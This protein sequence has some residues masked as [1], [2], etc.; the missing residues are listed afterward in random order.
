MT[1]DLNQGND[2]KHRIVVDCDNK[3]YVQKLCTGMSQ[4]K[5]GLMQ[6][7]NISMEFP[8]SSDLKWPYIISVP[9]RHIWHASGSP[10]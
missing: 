4:V 2:P 5:V 3:A 1:T 6:V 7:A 9:V 10:F 8:T